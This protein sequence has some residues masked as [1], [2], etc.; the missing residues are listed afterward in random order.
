MF[1]ELLARLRDYAEG[2]RTR[3]GFSEL[4]LF[5][6]RQKQDQHF[7]PAELT[8]HLVDLIAMPDVCRKDFSMGINLIVQKTGCRGK[9]L[10]DALERRVIDEGDDLDP[11]SQF[12]LA[13][14]LI[15]AGGDWTPQMLHRLQVLRSQIPELWLDLAIIAYPFD[16]EGLADEVAALLADNQT[17]IKWT[18]LK[19][20][21]LKLTN[22]TGAERFNWFAKKIAVSIS[23]EDRSDFLGWINSKR[24]SKLRP[25]KPSQVAG[26][27]RQIDVR[28][29]DIEFIASRPC[30]AEPVVEMEAA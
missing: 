30:L 13:S 27:R 5:L 26:M 15:S 3:G 14:A 16:V 11:R 22:A 28:Q 12:E 23:D 4:E 1:E 29:D 25:Q 10:Q 20:R 19:S 9:K 7:D 17:G 24:G 21:Y 18:A 2:N 6:A 8:T